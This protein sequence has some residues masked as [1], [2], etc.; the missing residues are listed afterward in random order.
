VT[1]IQAGQPMTMLAT[2]TNNMY[3]IT[4][5][6]GDRAQLAPGCAYGQLETPGSATSRILGYFNAACFAKAPV[7][8]SDNVGTGFGNSGVGIVRGPAQNNFDISLAKRFPAW[9]DKV[10]LQFRAEFFNTF[11][12]PQF[13]NP[14]TNF[15][16]ATFGQ[17][18][19]TSVSPRLV[20]LALRL[21]F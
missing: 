3:G 11:N 18:T 2:N 1:T 21:S 19:A 8:G 9:S 6:G 10:A 7:I 20:Q 4:A 13:A 12:T 16:D 14:D 17:I 15:S 5:T